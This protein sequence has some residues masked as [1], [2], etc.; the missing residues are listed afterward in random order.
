M[1]RSVAEFSPL[2]LLATDADDLAIVAT[3]LQD[4]VGKIGDIRFDA[5]AR[6]LTLVVN[7]YCWETGGGM[8]VRAGLQLG[9]VLGVQARRLRRTAKDAVIELLTIGFEAGDMPSGVINL[10]FAGGGDMRVEVECLDVVL[11]DLSRPWPARS[12]PGHDLSGA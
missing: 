11:A 6:V 10:A 3:T 12:T 4:A 1:D 7:R 2:K 5:R 9:S 8:R